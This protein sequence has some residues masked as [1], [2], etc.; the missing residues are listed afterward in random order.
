MFKR[1]VYAEWMDVLPIIA[2]VLTFAVFTFAIVRALRMRK[3]EADRMARLPVDEP[4]GG[5]RS[6]DGSGSESTPSS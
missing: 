3:S 5:T 1:V 6:S 4:D 2:F